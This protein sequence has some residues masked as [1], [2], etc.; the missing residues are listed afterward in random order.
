MELSDRST[1]DAQHWPGVARVPQGMLLQQRARLAEKSFLRGCARFGVS[2]DEPGTASMQIH[3]DAFYMRLAESDW[4]GLSESFLAGEWTSAEL[5]SVLTRLMDAGLDVGPE[6]SF[7]RNLRKLAR[8]RPVLEAADDGGELPSSLLE[9]YAGPLYTAGSALFSSGI[10]TTS[11][12]QIDNQSKGAGRGGIPAQWPVDITYVDP[13]QEVS[14]ADLISAQVNR[15]N[16]LLDMG[17]VQAGDRVL[18]W[19][20]TVGEIALRAVDRGAGAD[21]AAVSDDHYDAAVRRVAEAGMSGPVRVA[22]ISRDLASPREFDSDFEA[23]INVERMETFSRSAML[24]WLRTAE[25]L[26]VDR[27]TI[28]LQMAIAT[29]KFDESANRSIDFLRSYIWPQ[30]HYMRIEDFRRLVDRETGLRIAAEEYIPGHYSKTLELQR[31]LFAGNSRQ[32]AA[33]GYDRVFRRLWD[34]NLALQQALVDSGRIT[35]VQMELIHKP[36]RGR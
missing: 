33:L 27:G 14:R 9:L 22:R 32:A 30:A 35:M 16:H 36:R 3:D 20:S 21:I 15:I 26:L 12:E 5:P 28:V 1:I 17:R 13:P 19:P 2:V 18:E 7:V 10:R 25:R 29:G 23:I 31:A 34:Y 11:R 6:G 24:R 8:S 4:L